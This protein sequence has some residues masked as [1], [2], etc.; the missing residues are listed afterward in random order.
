MSENVFNL[1]LHMIESFVGYRYLIWGYIF[2]H[3]CDGVC[4]FPREDIKISEAI[5]IVFF[6]NGICFFFLF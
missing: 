3:Y 2:S 4:C 1:L 6:F 5:L